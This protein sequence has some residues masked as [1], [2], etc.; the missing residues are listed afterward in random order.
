MTTEVQVSWEAKTAPMVA[1]V[2]QLQLGSVGSWAESQ[3]YFQEKR[4]TRYG[5]LRNM[6]KPETYYDILFYIKLVIK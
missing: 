6:M 4:L 3:G 2:R 5:F 1:M